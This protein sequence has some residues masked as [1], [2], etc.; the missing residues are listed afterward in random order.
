MVVTALML[1]R[2]TLDKVILMVDTP[3]MLNFVVISV[4]FLT[5]LL[6]VGYPLDV[7]VSCTLGDHR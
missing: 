7:F 3:T 5:V 6:C 4:T 2:C 1:E